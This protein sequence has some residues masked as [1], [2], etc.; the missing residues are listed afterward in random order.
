MISRKAKAPSSDKQT[1]LPSSVMYVKNGPGGEWWSVAK[2]QNQIHAGW[3]RF[4]PASIRNPN[5]PEIKKQYWKLYPKKTKQGRTADLNA[6]VRL[7]DRPSQHI[8]ITFQ[9]GYLWWCT[10]HDRAQSDKRD[11]P[12]T[13]HFWL[14]CR[15]PWS[16]RS[17]KGTLLSTE[18]LPGTVTKV[19]GF[20]ATVCKPNAW[21]EILRV[22]QDQADPKS[23]KVQ[24]ARVAYEQAMKAMI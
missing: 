17:I 18:D 7:L 15:R 1:G 5:I 2:R 24:H 23:L 14:S 6:L 12:S 3:K 16:N 4:A 8:W 13:G 22:I 10:V 21:K 20:K 9:S 11:A 19:A